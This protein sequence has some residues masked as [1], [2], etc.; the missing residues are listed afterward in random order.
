MVSAIEE[1]TAKMPGGLP[2]ASLDH[3]D[4]LLGEALEN[5]VEAAGELKELVDLRDG[6]CLDMVGRVIYGI[7]LVRK[8]I[9]KQRPE[10]R[11]DFDIEY[12]QDKPRFEELNRLFGEAAK[13]E[14][15]G[16]AEAAR[17]LYTELL[18]RGRYGYFKLVAE[19]GLF[20]ISRSRKT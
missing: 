16:E 3:L 2:K 10:L 5:L 17:E 15:G 14:Q 13:A 20:R 6:D 9:Y 11:R 1:R 19:A 12:E 8:E 4:L 7:W 18:D